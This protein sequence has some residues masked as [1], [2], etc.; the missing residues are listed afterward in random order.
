MSE[1][2]QLQWQPA[3]PIKFLPGSSHRMTVSIRLSETE[4][5]QADVMIEAWAC[6][7]EYEGLMGKTRATVHQLW[8]EV[9]IDCVMPKAEGAVDFD[10]VVKVR[11]IL[12]GLPARVLVNAEFIA[13]SRVRLD[14]TLQ[15][16]ES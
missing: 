14:P 10:V 16:G 4:R 15:E 2:D 13:T 11:S 3:Q 12:E 6:I 9:A 1:I 7:G 8:E 5:D